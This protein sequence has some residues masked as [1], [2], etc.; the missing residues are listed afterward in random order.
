MNIAVEDV[1]TVADAAPAERPEGATQAPIVPE[2]T[3]SDSV[4]ASDADD[5]SGCAVDAQPTSS[6]ETTAAEIKDP[7]RGFVLDCSFDDEDAPAPADK[8]PQK[9]P[10]PA[11][12][13][14]PDCGRKMQPRTLKYS[15]ARTCPGP[16]KAAVAW[17]AG[18]TPVG[19]A[20]QS[21]EAEVAKPRPEGPPPARPPTPEESEESEEPVEP[22]TPHVAPSPYRPPV[23]APT[24]RPPPFPDVRLTPHLRSRALLRRDYAARSQRYAGLFAG[25][26]PA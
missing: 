21:D 6:T 18:P 4:A 2:S 20:S 13:P 5:E 10:A 7:V 3:G 8:P 19:C 17:P 12:V 24:Q 26:L 16:P 11:L 23:A 1:E 22:A 15:H 9:R 25:S 14:C